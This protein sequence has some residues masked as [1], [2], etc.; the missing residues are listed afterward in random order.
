MQ[1]LFEVGP[2][3]RQGQGTQVVAVHREHVKSVK[4]DFVIVLAGMQRVEIGDAVDA[5]NDRLAINDELLC[6][7][8]RRGLDDPSEK[9][10]RARASD[11]NRNAE[12][13]HPAAFPIARHFAI[14]S[15]FN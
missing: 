1:Q 4:P 13:Y 6:P 5:E 12:A 15:S 9:T 10:S 3:H 11:S 2:A 8:L 7:V 14:C